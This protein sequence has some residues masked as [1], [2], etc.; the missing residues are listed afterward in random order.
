[1]KRVGPIAAM[2]AALVAACLAATPACG[3]SV[4][5]L[6]VFVDTVRPQA[7]HLLEWSFIALLV[8]SALA[9]WSMDLV[10]VRARLTLV[11]LVRASLLV[12]MS[13]PLAAWVVMG[14]VRLDSSAGAVLL[15]M[16]ALAFAL[17]VAA[18]LV[19]VRLASRRGPIALFAAT[20]FAIVVDQLAGGRL[21]STSPLGYSVLAGARTYGLGNEAAAILFAASLT[22]LALLADQMQ[23]GSA[24]A[25]FCRSVV[26]VVGALVVVVAGAPFL[27]ANVGVAI[28]ATVG[29]ALFW[30]SLAGKQLTVRR[31]FFIAAIVVLTLVVFAGADLLGTR[32]PTHLGALVEAVQHQGLG[33][34]GQL[35]SRKA[36]TNVRVL[37]NTRLTW[38]L[39][40]TLAF[41]AFVRWVRPNVWRTTLAENPAFASAL[42]AACAAGAVACVTEDSGITIP[43]LMCLAVGLV[44]AWLLL[45]HADRGGQPR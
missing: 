37:F 34:L 30:L 42:V 13:S 25:R 18:A 38:M 20:G 23:S 16:C 2:V 35:I 4:G 26:P 45:A 36:A 15:W 31:A 22:V 21:A 39:V 5:P 40:V 43:S 9:V 41:A 29:F 12:G 27:G 7:L 32:P 17:A 1:M 11:W 19:D 14:V 24:R 33:A 28:W 8:V 3:I 10:P 6:S 44:L